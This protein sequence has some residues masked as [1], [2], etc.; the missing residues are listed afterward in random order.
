MKCFS[1]FELKLALITIFFE[2]LPLNTNLYVN[3]VQQIINFIQK[4]IN[5]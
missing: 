3:F 4:L 5:L 1:L 2:E